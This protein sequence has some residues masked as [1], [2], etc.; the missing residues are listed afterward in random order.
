MIKRNYLKKIKKLRKGK[1]VRVN[2]F[3]KEFNLD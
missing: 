3:T 1:F 2:D